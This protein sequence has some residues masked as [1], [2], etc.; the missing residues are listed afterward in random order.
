MFEFDWISL[1]VFARSSSDVAESCGSEARVDLR[2]SAVGEDVS[3]TAIVR[4][5][6]GVDE[7]DVPEL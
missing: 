6:K 3:D 2:G 5:L 1:R 7:E 4:S